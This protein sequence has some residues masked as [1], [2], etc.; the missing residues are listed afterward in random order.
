MFVSF[1]AKRI[2]NRG[3]PHENVEFPY[4]ICALAK[5]AGGLDGLVH[6]LF[7]LKYAF[8]VLTHIIIESHRG[9][10]HYSITG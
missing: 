4:G 1:V 7:Y 3:A 9:I 5:G 8:A 6:A 10:I 2:G